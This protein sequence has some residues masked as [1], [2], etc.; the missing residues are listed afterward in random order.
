M[1]YLHA[2]VISVTLHFAAGLVIAQPTPSPTPSSTQEVGVFKRVVEG[3]VRKDPLI[4][5][6]TGGCVSIVFVIL[7]AVRGRV[8]F[9]VNQFSGVF[10]GG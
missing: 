1:K 5:A 8:N 10:L 3:V 9:H 7:L 2:L 6:G 4:A